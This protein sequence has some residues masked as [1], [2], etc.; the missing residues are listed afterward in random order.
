MIIIHGPLGF[1]GMLNVGGLIL[2]L[3][4]F[5]TLLT[6]LQ[7]WIKKFGKKLGDPESEIKSATKTLTRFG[8]IS[9]IVGTAFQ[10]AAILL[11]AY[12]PNLLSEIPSYFII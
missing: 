5:I 6:Q 4:G 8:I 9:V 3:A 10:L 2:Q 11:T 1:A 12:L 7:D